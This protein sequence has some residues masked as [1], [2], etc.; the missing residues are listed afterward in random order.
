[1]SKTFSGPRPS[2]TF[3]FPGSVGFRKLLS[4]LA[5]VLLAFGAATQEAFASTATTTTLAVTS[6]PNAQ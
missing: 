2:T 1:M 6:G 3:R 4:T 5:V